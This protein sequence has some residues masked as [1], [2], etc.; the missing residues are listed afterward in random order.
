MINDV[1]ETGS[2][3]GR[4]P[5]ENTMTFRKQD[6]DKSEMMKKVEASGRPGPAHQALDAFVGDW[7]AE[8]RCWTDPDS[9]PMESRGSS[10]VSWIMNGRFLQENFQGEMMGQPF[11]R[12]TVIGYDNTRQT[13]NSVWFDDVHTSMFVSEGKGDNG[14]KVITLEGKVSCPVTGRK[15]VPMKAV[16]NIINR[17]KHTFEMF[18]ESKGESVRSM[19]I[20]YTRQ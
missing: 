12:R 8:V 6:M 19:E 4:A 13:F 16:L 17:D 18:D 9:P 5:A 15:E 11:N 14:F 10:K 7:K 20:I 1:S 2:T 3:A